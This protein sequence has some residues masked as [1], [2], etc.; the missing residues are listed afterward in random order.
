VAL[1]ADGSASSDN[2]SMFEALK[3]AALIHNPGR[4]PQCWPSAAQALQ[5]ATQGGARALGLAGRLGA[6]AP[7][8]LADITLLDLN[9]PLLTP[10]NDPIRQL[11]FCE[12]GSSVRTVIVDGQVVLE[13]GQIR[14]VDEQ[15][16]LREVRERQ[17][18]GR[19][20]LGERAA[21]S[22]PYLEAL[23]RLRLTCLAAAGPSLQGAG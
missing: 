7:G 22:R 15:E 2:Q 1:G 11:V 6:I 9:T 5:M 14:T 12:N 23:E 16:L 4:D 17:A 19:K 18:A 21:A 20:G 10:L 3:L 13:D 8:M